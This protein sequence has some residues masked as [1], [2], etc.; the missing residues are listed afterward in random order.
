VPVTGLRC[1]A[2]NFEPAAMQMK[3][4]KVKGKKGRCIQQSLSYFF[5]SS[6][7]PFLLKAALVAA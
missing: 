2:P 7:L 5:H 1:Q 3:K 6:F 4:E